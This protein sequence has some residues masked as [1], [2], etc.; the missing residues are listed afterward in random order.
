ML[1]EVDK[2]ND[3][4]Q[5]LSTVDKDQVPIHC[6]KKVIFKLKGAKQKTINLERLRKE[7]LDIEELETVLTSKMIS[8]SKDIVNMDFVID[9]EA[10]KETVQPITNELLKKL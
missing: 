8:M 7:G 2:I 1:V 10:V 6:V 5:V 3:W 4:E 9:V